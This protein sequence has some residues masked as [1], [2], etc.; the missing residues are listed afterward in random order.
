MTTRQQMT[1]QVSRPSD[2]VRAILNRSVATID[3]AEPLTSVAEMLAAGEVGALVVLTPH[4]PIG[5]ISERDVV[6]LVATN[7]DLGSVEAGDAMSPELV[8]AQEDDTIAAVAAWMLD[9]GIRHVPV[10]RDHSLVGI[11]SMRDVLAVMAAATSG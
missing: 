3:T 9:Y 6:R 2:P 10:M 8:S 5:V 11:V 1:P 4:G 7:S